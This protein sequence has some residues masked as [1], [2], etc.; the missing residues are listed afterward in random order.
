MLNIRASI[1][2]KL[3]I[4]LSAIIAVVFGL[5]TFLVDRTMYNQLDKKMHE[6]VTTK[7]QLVSEMIAMYDK[8]LQK[9]ADDLA[10]VLISYYPERITIDSG[11]EERIGE[12]SAPVLRAGDSVINL[13]TDRIDKFTSVTQ[14]AAT[15]F[16]RKDDDFI[17]ITTSLKK[18]D[19]TRAIG[20]LLGKD[21]P[22]YGAIIK[23]D[24]YTGKATLF[25]KDYMT[26]YVPIK[27]GSGRIIGIFFV[28]IEFTENLKALKEKILSQKVGKTGYIFAL[29]ARKGSAYGALVVHPAQEGS[30]ILDSKDTDG[31]E[32][33]REILEKKNGSITYPWMNKQLGETKPRDKF[34][35]YQYYP[36]WNWVIAAST[37]IDEFQE[38]TGYLI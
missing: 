18:N 26:R 30:V 22:S 34:A 13:K 37:Y 2:T 20:T 5:A 35:V 33:I 19:G 9:N 31:K 14:A 16:V 27:D 25:G 7:V 24:S 17:R 12:T 10:S 1:G 11:K 28:G 38:E 32:F 21:H 29:D 6:E 4:I 15:I 3:V 8:S 36:G 23:G